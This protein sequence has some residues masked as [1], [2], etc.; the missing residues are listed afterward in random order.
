M[1]EY[2]TIPTVPEPHE[3]DIIT[4]TFQEKGQPKNIEVRIVQLFREAPFEGLMYV[5]IASNPG[6][7]SYSTVNDIVPAIQPI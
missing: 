5:E 2:E 3:G 7:F 4:C 6:V 1:S